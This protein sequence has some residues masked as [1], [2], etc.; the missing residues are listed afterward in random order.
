MVQIKFL[1]LHLHLFH[2]FCLTAHN[3]LH[4]LFFRRFTLLLKHVKELLGL[5]DT[6]SDSQQNDDRYRGRQTHTSDDVELEHKIGNFKA[7][8]SKEKNNDL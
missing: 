5:P 4:L 8:I 3:T 7:E 2:S 1:K 6:H